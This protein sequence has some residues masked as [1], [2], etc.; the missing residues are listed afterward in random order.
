MKKPQPKAPLNPNLPG[1]API[2]PYMSV[3][4]RQLGFSSFVVGVFYTIFPICGMVAKPVM[5]AIA[6]H[7]KA[8]KVIFILSIFIT[9]IGFLLTNYVPSL[10]V[11]KRIK[12]ACD[13]SEAFLDTCLGTNRTD[14]DECAAQ[15][16]I[17]Q[18]GTAKCEVSV[19]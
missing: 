12:F 1:T 9:A 17:E 13:Q 5:G 3:F 4:A 6:D 19:F 10:P 8:K 15:E 7:F 14:T 2:Q 16:I 18:S 11:N